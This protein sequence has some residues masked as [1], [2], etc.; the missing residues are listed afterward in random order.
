[1]F[2]KTG[3]Q[4]W[5]VFLL[6]LGGT[7]GFLLNPILWFTWLFVP[8]LAFLVAT[9]AQEGDFLADPPVTDEP[10]SRGILQFNSESRT[11]PFRLVM[12]GMEDWRL[13]PF[14][15]GFSAAFYYSALLWSSPFWWLICIPVYGIA[16][17]RWGWVH[18]TSEESARRAMREA[19]SEWMDPPNSDTARHR[20]TYLM[21]HV[22]LCTPPTLIWAFGMAMRRN[23]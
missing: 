23:K 4:W 7:L 8:W 9:A 15:S 3:M 12:F 5:N 11:L 22:L 6:L 1:M 13:S 2:P 10:Q 19:W 20:N 14:W 18:S 21:W 16:I 17:A